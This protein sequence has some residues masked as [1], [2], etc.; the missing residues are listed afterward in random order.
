[1]K[2]EE[3]IEVGEKYVGAAEVASAASKIVGLSE[4]CVGVR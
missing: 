2:C 1:M 4:V 3:E